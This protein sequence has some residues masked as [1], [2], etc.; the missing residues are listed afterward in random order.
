MGSL[1]SVHVHA[2]GLAEAAPLVGRAFGRDAA[3]TGSIVSYGPSFLS[4]VDRKLS[5]RIGDFLLSLIMSAILVFLLFTINTSLSK[6][7]AYEAFLYLRKNVQLFCVGLLSAWI[8]YALA[9]TDGA[10]SKA[11]STSI[12]TFMIISAAVGLLAFSYIYLNLAA[13]MVILFVCAF[14]VAVWVMLC[15]VQGINQVGL[16]DNAK[17]KITVDSIFIA[18][19]ICNL[20]FWLNGAMHPDSPADANLSTYMVIFGNTSLLGRCVLKLIVG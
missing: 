9:F 6:E 5:D 17:E 20:L 11:T 16:N 10:Q 12:Y 7:T 8:G 2:D 1:L 4:D 18:F 19:Y 13:C 14:Y 3:N 15:Y